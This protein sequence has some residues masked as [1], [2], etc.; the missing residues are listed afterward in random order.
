VDKFEKN[1]L[2]I[3]EE[4]LD[5]VPRFE[6]KI[7]SL[8]AGGKIALYNRAKLLLDEASATE[9][10]ILSV[11]S[12]SD[13][14]YNKAFL[15][16][17]IHSFEGFSNEISALME[18]RLLKWAEIIFV[19]GLVVVLLRSFVFGL[20]HVPTSSAEPSLLVGDRVFGSKFEYLIGDP[21]VGDVVMFED[22]QFKYDSKSAF[23][24]FWQKNIGIEVRFLGLKRGPKKMAKR[25]VA[26]PGDVI[27]GRVEE[28]V[29]VV[30]RNGK[31]IDESYVNTY[32]LLA[33]KKEVGLFD[34]EKLGFIKIPEFLRVSKKVVL[35][36][37]D[38]KKDFEEQPFYYIDYR[39]VLYD[40]KNGYMKIYKSGVA[41]Q[42][43]EGREIDVFG[44]YIVPEGKYWVMGDNRKNS[45][46]SR[47]WG[48]VDRGSI[49]GKARFV[50]WSLDS[51]EPIWIFELLKNPFQFVSLI[52]WNRFLQKI[53]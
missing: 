46:D 16:V 4:F 25:V 43:S 38:P 17:K 18:S 42:N 52:R 5:K 1:F 41:S 32:P 48:F 35:Y 9:K 45:V 26:A 34:R 29:P 15:K 22:P 7:A 30:Y 19:V 39:S 14:K 51:E 20:Y 47:E 53:G 6:K 11:F 13:W 37:Y 2:R 23:R 31:K 12:T 33:L 3:R 24:R 27:E 8:K 50:I 49:T 44:P 10:E 28:G 36:S 21:Q 40:R